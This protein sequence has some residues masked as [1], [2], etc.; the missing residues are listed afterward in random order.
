MAAQARA[1]GLARGQA[2]ALGVLRAKLLRLL[3]AQLKRP[4]PADLVAVVQGQKDLDALGH[5]FDQAIGAISVTEVRV[6]FGLL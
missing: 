1:E 5:W 2:E 6:A 3:G 4:L